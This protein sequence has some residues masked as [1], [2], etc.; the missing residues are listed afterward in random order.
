VA[1]GQHPTFFWM[2][3][4]PTQNSHSALQQTL[5]KVAEYEVTFDSESYKR[6][7]PHLSNKQTH[8]WTRGWQDEEELWWR[9]LVNEH[10][11]ATIRHW[12]ETES[13]Q[14]KWRR[15]LWREEAHTFN[16]YILIHTYIQ[17]YLY[18]LKSPHI[19]TYVFLFLLFYVCVWLHTYF[20][21]LRI[22]VDV[23]VYVCMYI[24]VT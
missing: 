1:F 23:Y 9:F 17:I 3:P 4:A 18:I 7:I 12:T 10:K 24:Y 19:H 21:C 6:W 5:I 20:I 11:E 16:L 2:C 15:G 8:C 14:Q 22:Y 13:W